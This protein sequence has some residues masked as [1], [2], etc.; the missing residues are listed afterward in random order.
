MQ[1]VFINYVKELKT[2]KVDSYGWS[3]G[4]SN[5]F[6]RLEEIELE[7]MKRLTEVW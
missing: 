2:N 3:Q 7:L 5:G 4:V 1:C 6:G